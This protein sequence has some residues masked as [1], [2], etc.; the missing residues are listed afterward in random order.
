MT[1]LGRYTFAGRR[2]LRCPASFWR[3]TVDLVVDIVRAL[4]MLGFIAIVIAA[5]AG[6][7]M[8]VFS[9]ATSIDRKMQQ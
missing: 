9:I 4:L 8:I 6:L 5:V 1:Q 3:N 7:F 2:N